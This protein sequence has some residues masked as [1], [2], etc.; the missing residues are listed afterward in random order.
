[1]AEY[2]GLAIAGYMLTYTLIR[3]LEAKNVLTRLEAE[4]LIQGAIRQLQTGGGSPETAEREARSI[5]EETLNVV[6]ESTQPLPD[7]ER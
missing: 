6:H 2:G 4:E 5:L 3:K 7:G 1:M